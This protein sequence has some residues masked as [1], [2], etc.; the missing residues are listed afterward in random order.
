MLKSV[1]QVHSVQ[2]SDY[3]RQAT[4]SGTQPGPAAPLGIL[5]RR[6][7]QPVSSVSISTSIPV[8]ATGIPMS[9]TAP[10]PPSLH[11]PCLLH[12]HSSAHHSTLCP[13]PSLSQLSVPHCPHLCMDYGPGHCVVLYPALM[14]ASWM[15]L[16]LWGVWG[17]SCS[18]RGNFWGPLG[19]LFLFRQPLGP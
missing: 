6:Q 16:L 11:K 3:P 15:T 19:A 18:N 1:G 5:H 8:P 13:H 14:G 17:S 4:D 7:L 2:L 10:L 12:K 9:T